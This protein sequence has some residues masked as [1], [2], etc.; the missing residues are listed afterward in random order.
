MPCDLSDRAAVERLADTA[1]EVDVLVANAGL[2]GS[3]T[4]PKLDQEEIDRVLEVNL[5]API[6]LARRLAPAMVE[7][8]RGQLVFV[9]SF[10]GKV[11]S[12]GE[13]SIYTATK[14]GLRGFAH[15]LRAQMR[16]KGVGVS[17]VTPGPVREAGMF[18]RG[19]AKPPPLIGTS[20]PED[21]GKAV[22]RAIERNAAEID[23]AS[24]GLRAMSKLGA[25]APAT[26]ADRDTL[27]HRSKHIVDRTQR[28]RV[29]AR[30]RPRCC[31][32]TANPRDTAREVAAMEHARAARLSRSRRPGAERHR[33]RDGACRRTDD[34]RG[35]DRGARGGCSVTPRRW[36]CCSIGCTRSPRL[37]GSRRRSATGA[38][39]LHLDLHPENVILTRAR[40]RRD[41]LAQRG[42]GPAAAD[43]AHTWIVLACS[44]P[45]QDRSGGR[46][47]WPGGGCSSRSSCATSTA[48]SCARIC[49]R[50]RLPRSPT[51]RSRP[52]ELETSIRRARSQRRRTG[53]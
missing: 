9:A 19:G 15:V 49:R 25:L 47:R 30:R 51:A 35:H 50:R 7:R 12:A 32:V 20:S 28:G 27:R 10:A 22:V 2:P 13:S 23:V 31:A 26:I 43:V 8:G 45:P 17:L 1:G 11:P 39:L 33:H 40:A 24:L 48:P 18:A 38:A 53:S 4:L 37:T 3:G 5:R 36:R 16:R 6:A 41:R 34:A 21:V 14:F 44:L 46:S 29:R 52:G 42:R